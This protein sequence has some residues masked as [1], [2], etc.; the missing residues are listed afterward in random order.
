M[1][2]I[3]NCNS[4]LE[5]LRSISDAIALIKTTNKRKQFELL[6]SL[7]SLLLFYFC[8]RQNWWM[9]NEHEYILFDDSFWFFVTVTD[10]GYFIMYS[11]Q[12]MQWECLYGTQIYCIK[13]SGT[14]ITN[15]YV[16]M[17]LAGKWGKLYAEENGSLAYFSLSWSR[18]RTIKR[19]N[20]AST[21]KERKK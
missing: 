10:A 5:I 9:K 17:D 4:W 6:W 3:I 15:V 11:T 1:S 13:F 7:S 12:Y 19:H 2:L 14:K 8:S 21:E 16:T 18:M 20:D